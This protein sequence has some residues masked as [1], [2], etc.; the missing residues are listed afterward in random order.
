MD[1]LQCQEW[2]KSTLPMWVE[3]F[4]CFHS[5]SFLKESY[6]SFTCLM[7]KIGTP[8][9]CEIHSKLTIKTPERC[10]WRCSDVFIVIFEQISQITLVC[11]LLTFFLGVSI[12]TFFNLFVPDAPFLYSLKTSEN[13]KGFWCFQRVGKGCI[14]NEWV[15]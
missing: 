12:F 10:H 1:L 13:R 6:V 7:S 8:E 11:P 14:G 2:K 9:Q 4:Q 3:L 15:K 5:H